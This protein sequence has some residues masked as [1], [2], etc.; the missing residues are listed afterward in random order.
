MAKSSPH[1]LTVN[2][3]VKEVSRINPETLYFAPPIINN[4]QCPAT[5]HI[6]RDPYS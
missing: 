6:A 2:I 1:R 4:H 3:N 5:A